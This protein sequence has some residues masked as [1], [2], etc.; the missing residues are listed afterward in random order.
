MADDGLD[1]LSAQPSLLVAPGRH[2]SPGPAMLDRLAEEIVRG[3]R[4]EL[5]VADGRKR[6]HARVPHAL[7]VGAVARRA[8]GPVERLRVAGE[9]ALVEA[10]GA[11]PVHGPLACGG[12]STAKR[13]EIEGQLLDLRFAQAQ[14][15]HL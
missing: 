13:E 7:A 15:R 2:P 8:E 5:R 6:R 10:L 14:N 12:D 1:L 9:L 11:D 4:E 3:D